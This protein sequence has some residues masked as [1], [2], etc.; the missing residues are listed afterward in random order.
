M[1]CWENRDAMFAAAKLMDTVHAYLC[2]VVTL[3]EVDEAAR[4]YQRAR[5]SNG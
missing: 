1:T 5:G 2:G 3:V 4:E